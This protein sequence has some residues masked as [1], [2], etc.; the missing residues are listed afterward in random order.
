MFACD[1][2]IACHLK[3]LVPRLG[4]NDGPINPDHLETC[5]L[6]A[7]R[8]PHGRVNCRRQAIACFDRWSLVGIEHRMRLL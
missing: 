3:L 1:L 6:H 2:L 8:I 7:P 5:L 4:T